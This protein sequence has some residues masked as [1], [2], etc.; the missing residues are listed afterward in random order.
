MRSTARHPTPN[1]PT[2]TDRRAL[3]QK[4]VHDTAAPVPTVREHLPAGERPA[5][6]AASPDW[7]RA[8]CPNRTAAE[9]LDDKKAWRRFRFARLPRLCGIPEELSPTTRSASRADFPCP[10]R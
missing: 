7:K 9:E 1:L 6:A 3:F 5:P 10:A 2:A 4:R 8:Q